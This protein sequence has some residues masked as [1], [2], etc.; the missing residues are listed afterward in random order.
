MESFRMKTMRHSIP[1]PVRGRQMILT[2]EACRLE[3]LNNEERKKAV[4][5]LAQI[6]MQAAGHVVAKE[7]GDD[8]H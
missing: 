1:V 4:L 3:G 5:T 2:F 8:Q 7:F 6:L